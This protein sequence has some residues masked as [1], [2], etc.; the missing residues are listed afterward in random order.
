MY[1][2][3]VFI[4][5]IGFLIM[6]IDKNKARK[7]KWRISEKIIW[8]FVFIGGALGVYLGMRFFRH[9][10]KHAKFVYGVPLVLLCELIC[11]VF[12]YFR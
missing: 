6:G 2:Y 7:G 8:F 10:T 3:L 5:F 1:I 4:N 12:I 11:L 9:K